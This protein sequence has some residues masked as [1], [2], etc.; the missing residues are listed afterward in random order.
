MQ[1]GLI[2]AKPAGKDSLL[3]FFNQVLTTGNKAELVNQ[4]L[5]IKLNAPP[6][7][8]YASHSYSLIGTGYLNDWL[9]ISS[10]I[11]MVYRKVLDPLT[12]DFSYFHLMV[13]DFIQSTWLIMNCQPVH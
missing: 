9:H 7:V 8:Y 3:A 1:W 10:S 6:I 13:R 4:L 12:K 11:Q 5:F 2:N